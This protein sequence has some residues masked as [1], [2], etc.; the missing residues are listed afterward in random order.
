MDAMRGEG[1]RVFFSRNSQSICFLAAY[2]VLV[3]LGNLIYASPYGYQ[4]ISISGYPVSILKLNYIFSF[5]FWVLLLMPFVLTPLLIYAV[6][7]TS[8][9]Q[10]DFIS[11]KFPEITKAWFVVLFSVSCAYII[12][13]FQR[14]G[15]ADLFL[16][17]KDSVSSVYARFE[18][19]NRLHF[20]VFLVMQ[21]IVPYLSY[22][23]VINSTKKG[24]RFWFGAACISILMAS[25]FFIMINMKWPIVLYYVGVVLA[26]FI[27]TERHPYIKAAVGGVL[28]IVSYLLISTV[29]FRL[30]PEPI[31]AIK[32]VEVGEASPSMQ[33]E[34]DNRL[35]TSK[36][37]LEKVAEK[38]EREVSLTQNEV[39]QS[40]VEGGASRSEETAVVAV[41]E[42]AAAVS[43]AAVGAAPILMMHLVS[44][45]SMP[46]PYYYQEFTEHP[47]ACGGILV[48]AKPGPA[49][50]PSTYIYDKMFASSNDE[51][52]G[53]G[54]TP[55]AVH[56]S[57]YALGGWSIAVL[58]LTCAS[59]ILGIFSCL[60]L[61]A[62]ST[63]SAFGIMGALAGY[64]FSQVPGE[65]V[66]FYE[67]GLFW[68][69]LLMLGYAGVVWLFGNK[70]RKAEA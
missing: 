51:F 47:S 5:G 13:S 3:V 57:G 31:P 42:R 49:C 56:I 37:T 70:V 68:T 32:P 7:R 10:V 6:K 27:H 39:A 8:A 35:D 45:M 23:A 24:G 67:H 19:R 58:A 4:A 64:H 48:Q 69:F 46:Y 65:G 18:I 36:K 20:T 30:A 66:I 33:S 2:F 22:V 63:I 59:I 11:R 12:F 60:P 61:N 53:K 15:V 28:V 25:L 43:E 9:H 54:T 40:T 44:R 26:I 62:S 16:S 21:A 50:R 1:F 34:S 29:V 55:A 38:S 17:G 52:L 14:H 41:A